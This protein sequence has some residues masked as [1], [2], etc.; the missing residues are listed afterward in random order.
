MPVKRGYATGWIGH[1]NHDKFPIIAGQWKTF[2][3]LT[4][5]TRKPGLWA[6]LRPLGRVHAG[7]SVWTFDELKCGNVRASQ[8]RL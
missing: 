4:Y 5:D 6:A 1:L 2:E 7:L 8:P 3:N